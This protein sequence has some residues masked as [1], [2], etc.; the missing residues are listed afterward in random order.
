VVSGSDLGVIF[1]P[2][3]SSLT[4]SYGR[5]LSVTPPET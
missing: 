4:A 2:T 5:L 3:Y 1:V